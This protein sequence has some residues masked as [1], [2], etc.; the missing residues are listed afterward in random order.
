MGKADLDM[1]RSKFEQKLEKLEE[2]HS[3]EVGVINQEKA[4]LDRQLELV[5]AQ[6]KN[7]MEQLENVSKQLADMTNA[8]LNTS[9]TGADAS[10]VSNISVDED[11][12]NNCQLMAII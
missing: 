11:S 5:T 8:G 2:N 4:A 12:A 3:A 6:N 1:V 7:L 9:G 10:M